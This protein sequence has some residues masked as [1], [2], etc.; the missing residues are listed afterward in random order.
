MRHAA[1]RRLLAI[2]HRKETLLQI[3]L[4]GSELAQNR[5][6]RCYRTGQDPASG[7]GEEERREMR[8]RAPGQWWEGTP[9]ARLFGL[10]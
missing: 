10:L 1:Q 4:Y 7:R 5:E 3:N 2:E 8:P 9:V 6:L